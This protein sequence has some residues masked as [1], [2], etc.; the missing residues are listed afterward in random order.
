MT[1]IHPGLR[2]H[3]YFDPYRA[4]LLGTFRE[5]DDA[6]AFWQKR[7]PCYGIVVDSYQDSQQDSERLRAQTI[8]AGLNMAK[9]FP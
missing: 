5:Y 3:V 1:T 8:L 6:L 4:I 7:C 2:Y 9:T